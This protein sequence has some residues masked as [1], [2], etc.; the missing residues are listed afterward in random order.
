MGVF[1]SGG[2]G[3]GVGWP[4]LLLLAGLWSFTKKQARPWGTSGQAPPFQMA[5]VPRWEVSAPD[6]GQGRRQSMQTH[7][8]CLL[9]PFLFHLR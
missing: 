6:V 9:I 1:P 2:G 4:A 7:T 5:H 3:S 8:C